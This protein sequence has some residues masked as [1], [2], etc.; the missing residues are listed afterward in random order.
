M[1]QNPLGDT[2]LFARFYAG[3]FSFYCA[4]G[5]IIGMFKSHSLCLYKAERNW[6][7]T[8]HTEIDLGAKALC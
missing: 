1:H 8:K 6:E 2:I 3:K 4:S 7:Q 5:L